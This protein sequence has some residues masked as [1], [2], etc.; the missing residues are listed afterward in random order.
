[1]PAINTHIKRAPRT[2]I[3]GMKVLDQPYNLFPEV[4]RAS[5]DK[6]NA[7]GENFERYAYTLSSMKRGNTLQRTYYGYNG[8]DWVKVG[9]LTGSPTSP[10]VRYEEA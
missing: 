6:K 9:I 7:N 8:Q 5:F 10:K 1:M 3:D 4:V 2:K